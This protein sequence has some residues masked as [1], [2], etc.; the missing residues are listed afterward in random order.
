[1]IDTL[2]LTLFFIY[3][4]V[5]FFI[6]DLKIFL[7]FFFFHIVLSL[8]KKISLKKHSQFLEKNFLFILFL[9]LCNLFSESFLFSFLIGFRFFLMMDATF[10]MSSLLNP[11]SMRHAFSLLLYPLKIFKIDI[12]QASFLL[13]IAFSFIP[14]FINESK[15]IKYVLKSKGV[16]FSFIYFNRKPYIYFLI[17]LNKLFV[18]VEELEKTLILK[19]K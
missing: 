14:I 17:F 7:F 5:L 4:I 8:L 3:N 18:R 16:S 19:G 6:K 13:A 9:I 1:M 15:E 2:L 10:I 11:S 12:K